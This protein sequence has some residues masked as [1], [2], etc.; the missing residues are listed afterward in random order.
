MN[1]RVNHH[2]GQRSLFALCQERRPSPPE[3]QSSTSTTKRTTNLGESRRAGGGE[4]LL[5]ADLGDTVGQREAEVL[6]EELLDVRTLDIVGL[7]ELDDTEDLDVCQHQL[8]HVRR[9]QT[10]I[11]FP[12][13]DV[14]GWIGSGHGGGQPCP[15][16][17]PRRPRCGTS[18]GTPCT[19]CGY[20]SGSRSGSRGRSS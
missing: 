20:R 15:G 18:R 9:S 2:Q 10:H 19:C 12:R 4:D 13:L 6:A 1:T 11:G 8:V 7:L 14:R 17:E 5:L 16:K 3:A